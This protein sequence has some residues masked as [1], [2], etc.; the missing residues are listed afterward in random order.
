LKRYVIGDIHGCLK[1]FRSLIENRI[2][3]SKSDQIYLLGDYIDRGPDSSGVLDY[4]ID[5][6]AQGYQI[7]PLRGNHEQDLIEAEAEYDSDTFRLFVVKVTKSH[8]LLDKDSL[9][10]R[11]YHDFIQNLPFYYDLGN[12]ILVHAG[13]NFK[14]DDPFQDIIS[15]LQLRNT[16]IPEDG[17]FTKTIVHGHQPTYFDEIVKA[18][19]E[20]QQVLPIDNGC[21]FSKPHKVYDYKQLGKLC[22][23]NL[24]SFDLIWQENIEFV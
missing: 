9:L 19:S 2:R 1:T 8:D 12:I 21:S 7:F 23:L 13:I 4:I 10:K 17:S 11:K 6:Q 16:T 3:P 14:V 20:K 22:C 18:V 5:L 15:M 24:E